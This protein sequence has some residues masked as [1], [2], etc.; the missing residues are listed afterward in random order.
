MKGKWLHIG[1][2]ILMLSA[3]VLVFWSAQSR[4]KAKDVYLTVHINNPELQFVDKADIRSLLAEHGYNFVEMSLNDVSVLEL[5]QIL[6]GHSAL[7]DIKVF[8]NPKGK[9]AVSLSQRTPVMRV[10]NTKDQSY[11][12]DEDGQRMFLSNKYTADVIPLRGSVKDVDSIVNYAVSLPQCNVDEA[13]LWAK[14]IAS[15]E[16]LNAQIT[17]MYFEGENQLV[18]LTRLGL[19]KIE[20]GSAAGIE[21]KL[22]K[23]KAF[24]LKGLKREEW[25]AFNTIK[26]EY[27]N[28]VVCVKR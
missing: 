2:V 18:L 23:L 28:Q 7:K 26:L 4:S 5:K 27:K 20:A 10:F 14:A 11:Y 16:W 24:Y 17:D 8:K 9:V 3:L 6:E 22:K 19:H 21:K 12:I 15:D 1:A 25:N 13:Y